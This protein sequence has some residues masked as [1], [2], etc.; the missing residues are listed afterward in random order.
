[1]IYSV[2]P[3]TKFRIHSRIAFI[4]G[5]DYFLTA[6]L[7]KYG[8]N[9]WKVG[10]NDS[11]SQMKIQN[12]GTSLE[13]ADLLI[14][15][16]TSYALLSF[17]TATSINLI[18]FVTMTEVRSIKGVAGHLA[19][20]TADPSQANFLSAAE[21]KITKYSYLDGSTVATLTCDYIVSGM[22]NVN[23]S[24][25]VIVATWE[26]IFVYSFTGNDPTVWA[27][28]PYYFYTT[29]KQM[30]GGIRFDQPTATMYF[31]GLS[32]VTGL[33]D[34]STT[35]C[36][37]NCLTCTAMLSEYKCSGCKAPAVSD[38]GV[39][40]VSADAIKAPPGGAFS[41]STASWS[42]DSMKPAAAKG[43]NIKDYYLYFI[44]GGGGLVGIICI[45]C[46]C[47][48]CCKKSEEEQNASNQTRVHHQSNQPVKNVY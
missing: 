39:C 22:K 48:M 11:F 1:M 5:T 2:R 23:L 32:H 21:N 12:I 36:H 46:I 15:D 40:K 20:L 19:M 13:I 33:A 16:R 47:R 18:D 38:N 9:R 27:T 6:S 14:I 28:S 34:T 45:F 42:D 31:A 44:I 3:Q 25:F 29:G 24:D 4:E 43:F 7:S 10:K 30:P 35:Y 41:S 37:P 17:A 26:Q 8:V